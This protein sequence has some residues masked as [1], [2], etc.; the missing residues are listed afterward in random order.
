MKMKIASILLL[1]TSCMLSPALPEQPAA[2]FPGKTWQTRTP[3]EV[4]V[5]T[6]ALDRIRKPGDGAIV[7]H[8]YVIYSWGDPSRGGDWASA[9]KPVISTMLGI[10]VQEGKCTVD[11]RVSEFEPR[12]T[13][14]DAEI[15]FR[16]LATM[17]SGYGLV[18]PPGEAWA[19]NDVAI[20][21]YHNVLYG[22]VFR[23]DARAA[24][25]SRLVSHL[26]F[27]DKWS[28]PK[29]IRASV[30][31]MGR[32]GLLYLHYGNWKG[33]QVV[34]EFFV[35][36]AITNQVP[37]GLPRT[38]AKGAPATAGDKTYGGGKDQCGVGPGHYGHNF[39]TNENGLWPDVPRD[40]Y[41]ANGHWGEETVTVIPGYDLVI[42]CRGNIGGWK[43]MNDFL[44]NVIAA[45]AD[46]KAL[47]HLGSFTKWNKVEIALNG[48][49]SESLGKPNP[50]Q[51]KGEVV[52]MGPGELEYAVPAFYD[53]DGKGGMD[54]D[55]WKVRFSPDA[56]GL[57]N[58]ISRS[59]DPALDGYRGTFRAT[60]P[61]KDSPELFRRGRLEY[62]GEHYLRFRD[63]GFWFKVGADEPENFL[64][65]AFGKDAWEN[66]KKE[67]SYLAKKGINCMYVMTHTLDGDGKDVWPWYGATQN[68]AKKNPD[69]FDVAK[70]AKWED[71]FLHMQ[72]EG[73]VIHL[74]LEDDGAWTGFDRE[75]YYR[76]MV[77]RFGYL[78]ALYFNICEEHNERYSLSQ[79]L[80]HASLLRNLDPFHHPIAI[81]N[82][83]TPED[84]YLN[85]PN[86]ELTSI[87]GCK[88]GDAVAAF[89]AAVNWRKRSAAAGKKL[90]VSFDE[91]MN[92]PTGN[93]P[94]A[95][96]IARKTAWGAAL[97]G[98]IVEA[99]TSPLESF[100]E[101]ETF[102]D[103]LR[104]LRTFM[105]SLPFPKMTPDRSLVSKGLCFYLPESIYAICLPD[106][107]PVTLNLP[108]V[109]GKFSV[110]WYDPQKGIFREGD[111]REV[112]GGG[113]VSLGA[114]PLT[115]DAACIVKKV[116]I[117]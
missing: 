33:K 113:V 39:W 96:V 24:I 90:V 92:Y 77:A 28:V 35:R 97:G 61:D 16:H 12:L 107:G 29:R 78:P 58:F 47:G 80:K 112:T 51:T 91:Y 52:F 94:E 101:Y 1:L 84:A 66:K 104:H 117:R 31:D 81:H 105:E 70:L 20:M 21:L 14:K 69:R 44:A 41:Q 11:G 106:G 99:Y 85:N 88:E 10:A 48:T 5:S 53:G 83:N 38:G 100:A 111:M 46:P 86:I 64:G 7:R 82:V 95:R 60:E 109:G 36:E 72:N 65:N 98:G 50:F 18:E 32:F 13:G 74:V 63:G 57:W 71:A 116:G 76:E 49:M 75:L 114:P 23:Q 34:A 9:T 55:V 25:E 37:A 19:Y 27:E 2:V 42:S 45:V 15:T 103:D 40:A 110:R 54:G 67:V 93:T 6:A 26:Q 43:E 56:T 59:E 89:D 73:I 79:A 87:Q 68:E 30:R 108:G 3:E 62:V 17:T 4:G 115:G 102:W 8:G 22:K